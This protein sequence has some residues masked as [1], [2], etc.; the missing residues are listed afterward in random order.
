MHLLPD[1]ASRRRV[2]VVMIGVVYFGIS[3]F[4]VAMMRQIGELHIGVMIPAWWYAAGAGPPLVVAIIGLLAPARHPLWQRPGVGLG[5]ILFVTLFAL[6]SQAAMI[7]T[8]YD[9]EHRR[10]HALVLPP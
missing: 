1:N 8:I 10:R 9:F 6:V 3:V 5:L 7:H 2:W 4:G